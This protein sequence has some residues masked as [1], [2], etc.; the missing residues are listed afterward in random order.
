[1]LK[2][3]PVFNIRVIYKSGYFHD[4]EVYSFESDGHRFKWHEANKANRPVHIGADEIAAVYQ[5]GIR[6]KLKWGK[7]P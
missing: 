4:F 1:M 3:V 7:T 6:K 2:I 5:V